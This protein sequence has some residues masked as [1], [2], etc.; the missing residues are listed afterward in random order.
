MSRI[1]LKDWNGQIQ[2]GCQGKPTTFE[3]VIIFNHPA[4]VSLHFV[5]GNRGR[6]I[7]IDM[8]REQ[9]ATLA[10]LITDYLDKPA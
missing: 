5:N 10:K 3:G 2:T 7:F 8:T 4:P 1:V 6:P 9:A